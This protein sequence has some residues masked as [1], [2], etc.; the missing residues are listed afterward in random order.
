MGV[1]SR[2]IANTVF[3]ADVALF[4]FGTDDTFYKYLTDASLTI[5]TPSTTA[6]SIMDFDTAAQAGPSSVTLSASKILVGEG[7]PI[8]ATA[9]GETSAAWGFT[10]VVRHSTGGSQYENNVT[11]PYT[12]YWLFTNAKLTCGDGAV[13]ESLEAVLQGELKESHGAAATIAAR[14]DYDDTAYPQQ[15]S[16]LVIGSDDYVNL[17][18]SFDIDVSF[19][20]TVGSA[21]LDKWQWPMTTGR[22]RITVNA[23]RVVE[24]A[25]SAASL[26]W[27][28]LARARAAVPVTIPINGL[29]FTGSFL[30]EDAKWTSGGAGAQKETI[31]LRN[32]GTVT[33]TEGS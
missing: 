14:T 4:T 9:L 3:G 17:Y 13:T 15:L 26:F 25:S 6:K 12:G 10:A 32:N 28:E 21:V 29:T 33:M 30:V 16:S 2:T 22:D 20:T 8:I 5:S 11:T 19:G 23:S 31:T 7:V 24:N 1:K 18:D 27:L